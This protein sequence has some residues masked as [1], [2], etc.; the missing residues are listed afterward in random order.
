MLNDKPLRTR[1]NHAADSC[2]RK[3]DVVNTAAYSAP[4]T[5]VFLDPI[6]THAITDRR[7][8]LVGIG[9]RRVLVRSHKCRYD[10]CI[11][12]LSA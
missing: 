7:R 1:T 4:G 9:A 2:I 12:V 10:G 6:H 8:A 5:E 11:L 3:P